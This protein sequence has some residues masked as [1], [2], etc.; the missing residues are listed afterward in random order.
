MALDFVV[1][2]VKRGLSVFVR[3]PNNYGLLID[4][5]CSDLG[6][7]VEQVAAV[8]LS[9]W[10]NCH[11]AGFVLSHPHSDHLADVEL[12]DRKIRPSIVWRRTDLDWAKVVSSNRTLD[13][14]NYYSTHFCNAASYPVQNPPQPHWGGDFSMHV[15][16]LNAAS[17]EK[18]SAQDNAYVNNSSVVV[19][20]RYVGYTFAVLGDIESEG[21]TAL[22]EQNTAFATTVSCGVDFLVCS[23]HGLA[24]G[25]SCDWFEL[26]GPTRKF[27]IVSE[28][29]YSE[30]TIDSRYSCAEASAAGNR[31]QRRMVTTRHDGNIRVSIHDN[32]QWSWRAF[33]W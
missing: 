23:H 11:L 25:Y 28:G 4:C 19:L 14:L 31:E 15:T 12:L 29:S 6:S 7:P 24:S 22:L 1:F 5:G 32:R 26:T 21:M 9:T 33:D 27:N 20:L 18:V 3:T 8:R 17:V 30:Q 13:E 16:W 10:N 2:N